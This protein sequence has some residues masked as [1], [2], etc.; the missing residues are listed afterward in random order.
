MWVSALLNP[1]G[2][3]ARVLK[4]FRNGRLSPILSSP[5][6]DELVD[7]LARPRIAEKYQLTADEV[8]AYVA[9]IVERSS[10]VAV[11]GKIQMCRDPRDNVVLETALVGCA[12]Y[13]VSRDD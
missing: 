10:I 6:I 8:A 1:S 12:D 7:V 5:L 2:H 4:A 13:V 11:S 3:P 9:L